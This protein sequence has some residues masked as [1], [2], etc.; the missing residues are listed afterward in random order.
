MDFR[1]ARKFAAIVIG[2]AAMVWCNDTFVHQSAGNLMFVRTTQVAIQ[3]ERLVIG[4]PADSPRGTVIPIRV[5]YEM[6]NTSPKPVPADIGFPVPACPLGDYVDGYE[7]SFETDGVPTCVKQ[8]EMKLAVDDR[9]CRAN[10]ILY[11]SATDS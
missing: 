1:S 3:K 9:P 7:G 5:E 2:C 6:E 8:P 11:S 4:P 10:G